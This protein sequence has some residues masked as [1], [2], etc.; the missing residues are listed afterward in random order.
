MDYV[1]EAHPA[2]IGIFPSPCAFYTNWIDRLPPKCV[3]PL[4][5]PFALFT[6]CEPQPLLLLVC[7]RV[8]ETGWQCAACSPSSSLTSLFTSRS[9]A[10]Q[11]G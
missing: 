11:E 5:P 9:P 6:S 10:P 2:M 4:Q 1:K 8:L 7:T 3:I